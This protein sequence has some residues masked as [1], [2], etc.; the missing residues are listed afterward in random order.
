MLIVDSII[1]LT[2]FDLTPLTTNGRRPF[3]F[4]PQSFVE[5]KLLSN[6]VIKLAIVSTLH[7]QIALKSISNRN[8]IAI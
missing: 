8:C 4:K 5:T 6:F 2:Q 3:K 7:R 1:L